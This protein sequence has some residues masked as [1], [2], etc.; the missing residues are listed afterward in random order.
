MVVSVPYSTSSSIN[1]TTITC[2]G[3]K[4][5]LNFAPAAP[6]T[7]C[8]LQF[9]VNVEETSQKQAIE[10][11][12]AY[13]GALIS[14]LQECEGN[15]IEPLQNCGNNTGDE[16]KKSHLGV[17]RFKLTLGPVHQGRMG[18][19]QSIFKSHSLSAMTLEFKKECGINSVLQ[20]LSSLDKVGHLN[21][22]AQSGKLE[23]DH[24]I[25]LQNQS[26]ILLRGKNHLDAKK[27]LELEPNSTQTQIL[28][29]F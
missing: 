8:P 19:P 7:A 14:L 16:Q 24:N 13:T 20:S 3:S 29:N 17:M 27:C 1:K 25:Q 9:N 11:R 23:L 5:N 6:A 26:H 22:S 10:K 12:E 28:T 15:N 4:P 21:D 18:A 2:G